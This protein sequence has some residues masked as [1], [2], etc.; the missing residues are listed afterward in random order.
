MGDIVIALFYQV[1][2]NMSFD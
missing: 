1:N 2:T